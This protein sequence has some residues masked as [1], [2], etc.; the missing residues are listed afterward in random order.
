MN[1]I[2]SNQNVSDLLFLRSLFFL[3][4]FEHKLKA[5][6]VFFPFVISFSFL[7]HSNYLVVLRT[8]CVFYAKFLSQ[9]MLFSEVITIDISQRAQ[10]IVIN[11]YY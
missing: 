2:E 3:N 11:D 6:I 4:S 1:P 10:F 7:V 5:F 8:I 9:S